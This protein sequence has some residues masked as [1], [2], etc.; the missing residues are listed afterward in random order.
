MLSVEC[1]GFPRTFRAATIQ[2]NAS[3]RVDIVLKHPVSLV[4]HVED[5]DGKPVAGA[6]VREMTRRG[7]SGE[8]PLRQLW[9]RS[10]GI[11]IPPSDK[12][13]CLRLPPLPSGEIITAIFDHPRLAPVRRTI[14]RRPQMPRLG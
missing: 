8:C 4:I 11:T 7:G 14:S 1:A 3:E 5:Q 6:R 2:G 10:L 9:L 13:G 12:N